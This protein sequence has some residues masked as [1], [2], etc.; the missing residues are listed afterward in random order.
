[1]EIFIY[2]NNLKCFSVPLSTMLLKEVSSVIL[3]NLLIFFALI[4]IHELS[5]VATGMMLGCKNEKAVLIDS[6]LVGPYTELY[7]SNDYW[8]IYLSSLLITSSFSFLFLLLKTSTK[9]IFLIS[10]GLSFIF[11]SIDVSIATNIQY[12]F[13]PMLMGGFAIMSLGEYS[14]ASHYVRNEINIDILDLEDVI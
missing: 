1:M 10:L 9:K 7:C 8:A 12:L 11:S 3:I 6:N 4:S 13:Y 2:K 14:I 5:H